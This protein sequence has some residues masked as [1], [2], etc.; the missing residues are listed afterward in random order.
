MLPPQSDVQRQ[1]AAETKV[2]LNEDPVVIGIVRKL[3]GRVNVAA[4]WIT[5]QHVGEIRAA[6]AGARR[7][8]SGKNAVESVVTG[9]I[10][11]IVSGRL[12]SP[13]VEAGLQIV[14]A[15]EFRD[16][17]RYV[18]RS[19][20]VKGVVILDAQGVQVAH[21]DIGELRQRARDLAHEALGK[22]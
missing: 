2:V 1:L 12:D 15:H 3:C 17:R 9:R 14:P 11:R 16:G 21:R 13:I 19:V 22:S 18:L 6:G 7:S 5:G 10:V 8:R 20:Y 4:R